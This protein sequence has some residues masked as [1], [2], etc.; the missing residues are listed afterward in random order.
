[1]VYLSVQRISEKDGTG[2]EQ[3][4]KSSEEAERD[5]KNGHHHRAEPEKVGTEWLSCWH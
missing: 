3:I 5:R 4:Y 1:M 2:K